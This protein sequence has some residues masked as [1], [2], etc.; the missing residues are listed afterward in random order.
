M[1][2]ALRKHFANWK[3]NPRRWEITYILSR[4]KGFSLVAFHSLDS[5][6]LKKYREKLMIPVVEAEYV[7]I[8]FDPEFQNSVAQVKDI[9]CLDV[10]RLANM[11]N[12]AR[13]VG[14]GIFVEVGTYKGGTALHICNA[15]EHRDADF[16][17]FDPFEK[18]GFE[19][20]GDQDKCFKPSDFTDTRYEDVVN[21][22]SSKPK[23][24]VI[25]GFFPAA[26]ENLN[27]RDIAFCHLDVDTY[28]A[29]KDSLEFLAPR[30]ARRGLI[31][32]D[33]MGHRETPGVNTAV[34]EFLAAH[35]S[36]LFIP[37]FPVQAVLLPKS[38][39]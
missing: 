22:L 9:S 28:E 38:L 3:A 32:L 39:W 4:L 19:K 24:K 2:P 34:T 25:Q 37:M 14:P 23:A 12:L 15:I 16:Y 33:D 6:R 1:M 21:L 11:W 10:A 20:I 35:P 8:L 17:C 13:L 27:L 31:I 5:Y 18:G 36:F 29:T 26:A 30:M 7:N